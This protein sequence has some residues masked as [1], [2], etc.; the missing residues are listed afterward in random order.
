MVDMRQRGRDDL[1]NTDR[2]LY[3]L[4]GVNV[5]VFVAW[6]WSPPI[7][8]LLMN[9]NFV[10]SADAIASLRVWTLVTYGFSHVDP[11]HLV[12]NLLSLWVF[13][14]P[15]GR[16]YGWRDL[17]QL[18]FVGAAVAGGAH[19]LYQLGTGDP[20]PALGASGAVMALAAVYGAT[21]PDRTVLL[22]GVVPVQAA[23][24]VAGYILLDVFG[25]VGGGGTV[26]HAAHLG[27]A[28]WGLA[29][30]WWRNQRS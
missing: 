2:A 27:G 11:S 17:L 16:A 28:A 24:L 10:V 9:A 7:V 3:G 25:L 8:Q 23:L 13:G 20:S 12:F 21:F 18:Y 1:E 29:F 6:H 22:F 30:W 26:A 4:I 15:V 19:V 14:R 5:L